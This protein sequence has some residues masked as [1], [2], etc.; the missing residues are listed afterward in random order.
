MIKNETLAEQLEKNADHED[1]VGG[2]TAVNDIEA[3]AAKHAPRQHEHP[4]QRSRI[5]NRIAFSA[6]SFHRE[7]VTPDIDAVDLLEPLLVPLASRAYDGNE[8]TR[9]AKRGR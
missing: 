3:A 9:V 4:K 6:L 7:W 8:I 1:K 2:I 5:L